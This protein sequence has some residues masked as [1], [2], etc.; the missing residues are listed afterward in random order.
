VIT[1][2]APWPNEA[3]THAALGYLDKSA[4]NEVELP[5]AGKQS[6]ARILGFV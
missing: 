4:F 3:G 2:V 1:S 5:I 6:L